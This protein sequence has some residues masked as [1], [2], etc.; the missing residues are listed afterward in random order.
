MS[1]LYDSLALAAWS[2]LG[3]IAGG[4]WLFVRSAGGA[5]DLDVRDAQIGAAIVL[6]MPPAWFA[7]YASGAWSGRT[8][9]QTRAGL[10]VEGTGAR[11]ML[12]FAAHPL[13][14]PLWAWLT[15]ALLAA[16]QFLAAMATTVVLGAV[17]LG[18]IASLLGW[19]FR[20]EA[21]AVHDRIARTHVLVS[22]TPS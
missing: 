8:W 16:G 3:C 4:A 14:A 22:E 19:V 13:A 15:L 7:W 6:A 12:R 9:G 20:P 17:V 1:A 5:V 2:A 10:F 21:P 18:A 11:R